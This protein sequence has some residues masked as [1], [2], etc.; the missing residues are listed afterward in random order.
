MYKMLR[1]FCATAWELEGE[2][3]AFQD[4]IGEFNETEAMK[5][6]LLYVPVSLTNIRDKRPWQY[7]VEENIGAC[8]AY[9]LVL[10]GGAWGPPERNFERD[11]SLAAQQSANTDFPMRDVALLYR[12]PCSPP[13]PVPSGVMISPFSDT[14]DFVRQFREMMSAW[15]AADLL[16]AS[17]PAAAGVSP[18]L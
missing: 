1:V 3:R 8:R 14:G 10:A 6:G 11:L 7:E 13:E 4:A 17:T 18:A 15:L 5:R 16:E 9:L 12:E 2:R